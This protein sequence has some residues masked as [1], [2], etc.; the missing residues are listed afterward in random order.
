MARR[1]AALTYHLRG[2]G[3]RFQKHVVSNAVSHGPAPLPPRHP[4]PAYR[5]AQPRADN[6]AIEALLSPHCELSSGR[7]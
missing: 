2:F 6:D 4:E 7:E 3:A 5:T 1:S